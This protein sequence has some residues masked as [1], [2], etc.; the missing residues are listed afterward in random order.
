[1]SH[2]II[3]LDRKI[4]GVEFRQCRT[5]PDSRGSFTEV[6][7]SEWPQKVHYGEEIQLNLSRSMKG[8]LR[9][10]HYH[11]RQSDWWI[12]ISG[13]LQVAL[14]DLRKGS[15]TFKNTQTLSVCS[16]DSVCILI[17]PGVAHGFLAISDITLLYAVNQYYDGADE[18]G[19][20]W[21]DPTLSIA[22]EECNPIRSDRDRSNP[23]VEELQKAGLLPVF[24]Q[25]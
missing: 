25:L 24:G 23:T 5:F 9:G 10:L 17:P 6:F 20:A 3:R 18:Q 14:A 4:Q 21:N 7:R 19:V 22:W 11:H 2:N 8:A 13:T 12:P 15:P 1:M 16:D